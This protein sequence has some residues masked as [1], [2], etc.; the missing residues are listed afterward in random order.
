MSDSDVKLLFHYTAPTTSHLG[1]IL[2]DGRIRT[3][4]FSFA[5][6]HAGPDVVW[7]TDSDSPE[8]Q[9]WVTATSPLK[10]LA[11]LVVELD[12]ARVHH[13]PDW[14]RARGVDD[15][16]HSDSA[17]G[18]G[19]PSHWWISTTPIQRWDIKALVIAPFNLEDGQQVERRAFAHEDLSR[20]FRSAG[21]RRQL[22]LPETKIMRA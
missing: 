3:T 11:V 7:L 14:F 18:G 6:E 1:S 5:H 8:E 21:A 2:A 15:A 4:E 10:R 12:L 9:E 17:S 13:W 20:L 19:D 16:M 22:G